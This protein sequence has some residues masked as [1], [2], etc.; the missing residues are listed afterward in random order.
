MPSSCVATSQMQYFV[1]Y[2]PTQQFAIRGKDEG[3]RKVH[4]SVDYLG[5]CERGVGHEQVFW[6]RESS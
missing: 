5:T 6:I 3:Q 4:M 1:P 2:P